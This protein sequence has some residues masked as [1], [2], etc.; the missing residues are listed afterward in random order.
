MS[1][2]QNN[3]GGEESSGF[4]VLC[5][6]TLAVLAAILAITDLGAG[7][8]G[9]DEII[10]HNEMSSAYSWYQSKSI[11][12]SLV[13]G[14]G[15]TMKAL[16]QAGAVPEERRAAVEQIV[17]KSDA[18]VARYKQEKKEILLG[19]AKVGEANWVLDNDGELGK[20]KGAKEW[21]EEIATLGAAGDLFDLATLFLQICLVMGAIS[22]LLKGR[23]M[24][25]SFYGVMVALGGIGAVYAWLAFDQAGAFL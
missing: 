5:G 20:I 15:D 4:E 25:N 19:S 24:R 16:L 21:E 17:A 13:E 2:Q 14:Q 23:L 6:L 1:E 22:L 11:K 10:G 9:D 3:D 7:K 18:D 12:Q 8:Y